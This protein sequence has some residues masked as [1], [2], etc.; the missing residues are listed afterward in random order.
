MI[1]H[2]LIIYQKVMMGNFYY[3]S[4]KGI[5]PDYVS[6]LLAAFPGAGEKTALQ[7]TANELLNERE[8]EVMQLVAA[9]LTNKEIAYRLGVSLSTVKW[10]LYNL[11]DRLNVRNRTEAVARMKELGLLTS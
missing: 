1:K 3:L 6:Q 11:Y 10:Y 4:P 9:G 2:K 8:L 5:M 7:S